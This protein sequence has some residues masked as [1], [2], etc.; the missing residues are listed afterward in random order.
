MSEQMGPLSFG[1]REEQVFLGR[2]I[3]QHRDY[4]EQTA[5]HIDKEIR[6]LIETN[7]QRASDIL[8]EHVE[9]L[10]GIA[11]AL[12]EKETLD[13]R[14]VDLIISSTDPALM[15]KIGEQDR[16]SSK[17]ERAP[18]EDKPQQ[19]MPVPAT[20]EAGSPSASDTGK[21]E[22]EPVDSNE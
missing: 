21:S 11:G 6:R 13:L 7:Y 5:I 8:T 12:L 2:D 15:T 18:A 3:A 20:L 22:N 16:T 4:S 10:H 19:Q 1:K 14:D 9:I 17:P